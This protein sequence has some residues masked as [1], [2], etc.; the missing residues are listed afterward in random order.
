MQTSTRPSHIDCK[1][2]LQLGFA[3]SDDGAGTQDRANW[4]TGTGKHEEAFVKTTDCPSD[5]HVY[6]QL[7]ISQP[8][9]AAHCMPERISSMFVGSSGSHPLC[10]CDSCSRYV[11]ILALT[12]LIG[13]CERFLD[14]GRRQPW[15]DIGEAGMSGECTWATPPGGPTTQLA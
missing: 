13:P 12:Y 10:C 11:P 7:Q 14:E 5:N 15:F 2:C 6:I 4:F 9:N 8:T 1:D 3:A